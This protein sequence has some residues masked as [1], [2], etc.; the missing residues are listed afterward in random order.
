MRSH[1]DYDFIGLLLATH[2]DRRIYIIDAGGLMCAGNLKHGVARHCSD[3]HD[4]L[5]LH[6]GGRGRGMKGKFPCVA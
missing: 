5:V 1:V 6:N 2:S 4:A 3:L